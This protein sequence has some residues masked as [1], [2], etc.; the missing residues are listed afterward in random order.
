ME[1]NI[2]HVGDNIQLLKDVENESI[3]LIYFD[4]PYNTGRHF[5][6]FD[7]KFKSKKDYIEF[8]KMRVQECHRVLKETWKYRH[9][10]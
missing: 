3:D 1:N 7:D 6:D 10:C 8:I 2:Y 9:S 4:P 5:Y